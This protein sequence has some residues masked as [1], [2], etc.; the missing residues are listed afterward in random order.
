MANA[1]KHISVQRG[2][3]VTTYTLTTFGGAGGQRACQVADAL[4]MTQVLIHPFAGVLSAY[5]MGLA[6]QTA[7]REQSTE[8]LLDS[9]VFSSVQGQLE[10]L[11]E[12]AAADL[13]RQGV[14]RAMQHVARHVHLKYAGTDTALS[15]AWGSLSAMRT[16]FAEAYRQ[17]FSFLMPENPL[18]VEQQ[19]QIAE[20]TALVEALRAGLEER[21]RGGKRQ[22]APFSLE[23]RVTQPKPPG[24][25]PGA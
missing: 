16:A 22:A 10:T 20:L 15:V 1:I 9:S 17:R 19:R 25:K 12:D 11:A 5:G 23:T 7:M 8:A 21:R 3:D 24:R 4:G 14:P 13:E 6:E 18:V 2:H